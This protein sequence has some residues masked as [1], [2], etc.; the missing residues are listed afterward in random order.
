MTTLI[1]YVILV[2]GILSFAAIFVYGVFGI[3]TVFVKAANAI[4]QRR[5]HSKTI[6][7]EFDTD[8]LRILREDTY[9]NDDINRM[10]GEM[11]RRQYAEKNN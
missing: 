8:P 2:F 11:E 6:T 4:K 9:T 10:V 7:I 1:F 5:S 3:I